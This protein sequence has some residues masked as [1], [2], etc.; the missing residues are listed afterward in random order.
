VN[1][2]TEQQI[3]LPL[4]ATCNIWHSQNEIA[5][6]LETYYKNWGP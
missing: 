1:I 4:S 3:D 2:Y 5:G 6:P